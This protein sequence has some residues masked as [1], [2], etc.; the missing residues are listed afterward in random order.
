MKKV[1]EWKDQNPQMGVVLLIIFGFALPVVAGI[2]I[3]KI[4]KKMKHHTGE[5]LETVQIEDEIEDMSE[6]EKVEEF[7]EVVA[8]EDDLT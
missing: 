6:P 8:D 2:A 4:V 3:Y 7:K 5:V 1:Q